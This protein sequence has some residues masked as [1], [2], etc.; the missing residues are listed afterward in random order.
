MTNAL[1]YYAH[2]YLALDKMEEM[3]KTLDVDNE[4][5]TNAN[6]SKYR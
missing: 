5:Q 2:C 1:S 6:E 3:S 4:K